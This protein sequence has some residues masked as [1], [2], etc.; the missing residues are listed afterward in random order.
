MLYVLANWKILYFPSRF[1]S[2][3]LTSPV[4]L[5]LSLLFPLFRACS[6]T[7]FYVVGKQSF[8]HF[9]NLHT[10]TYQHTPALW[11]LESWQESGG[12]QCDRVYLL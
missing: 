7:C 3:H 6:Y 11:E 5:S 9:H 12:S 1:R 8:I 10:Y 2:R 4:S